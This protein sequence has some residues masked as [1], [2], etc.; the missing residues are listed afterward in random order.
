MPLFYN[1]FFY[2][3]IE[4]ERG[5]VDGR[6]RRGFVFFKITS[7]VFEKSRCERNKAKL[8]FSLEWASAIATRLYRLSKYNKTIKPH[9]Y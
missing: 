5:S 9:K 7:L 1:L 6:T 8:Y 4:N 3:F 2:R